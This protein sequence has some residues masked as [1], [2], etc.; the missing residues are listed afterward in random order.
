M[1]EQIQNE[2]SMPLE[3]QKL[4]AKGKVLNEPEKTLK[5]YNLGEG[6]FIVVMK[7]KVSLI[8]TVLDLQCLPRP[9]LLQRTF[10]LNKKRPSKRKMLRNLTR[11]RTMRL[12]NLKQVVSQPQ[13][14][15]NHSQ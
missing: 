15:F 7:E 6:S 9:N 1:K 12:D 2:H 14:Q 11:N 4:V 3:S 13:Q 5:D 10:Q 8:F